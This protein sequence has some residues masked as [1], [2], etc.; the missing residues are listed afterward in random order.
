MPGLRERVSPSVQMHDQSEAPHIGIAKSGDANCSETALDRKVD[1]PNIVQFPPT[2]EHERRKLS[3][4]FDRN[5]Q[6]VQAAAQQIALEFSDAPEF[7]DGVRRL[8]TT[9]EGLSAEDLKRDTEMFI[10]GS[11]RSH[12]LCYQPMSYLDEKLAFWIDPVRRAS[13]IRSAWQIAKVG[14]YLLPDP[15]EVDLDDYCEQAYDLL[16]GLTAYEAVDPEYLLTNSRERDL[17]FWH[18]LPSTFTV[19]RGALG[20]S[21]EA[22]A[23]GICWTTKRE[24]AEW[25]ALRWGK[26]RRHPVL[27]SAQ[28]YKT[29]VSTVFAN[30]YEIA[31]QPDRFEQLKIRWQDCG[32]FPEDG[33]WD[34]E[35]TEKVAELA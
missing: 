24:I 15:A 4:Y 16:S 18:S 23:A 11:R 14:F 33:E 27:V 1:S 32:H 26:G 12:Y 8:F 3:R 21:A 30:E 9:S 25:Y 2:L 29:E 31:V 20:V 34:G 22:C 13:V 7:L 28:I 6:E 5:E 17:D 10:S 35:V 19:Y